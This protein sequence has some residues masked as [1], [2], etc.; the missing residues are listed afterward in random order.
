MDK[1]N[2]RIETAAV[3]I[4]DKMPDGTVYAGISLDTG[5]PTY[6][7]LASAPLTMTF[8]EA[9]KYVAKMNKE[10]TLSHDDWR[11]PT[12]GD[13]SMLFNHRAD[14]GN[15]GLSSSAKSCLYWSD[16]L[17]KQDDLAILKDFRT[18]EFVVD[19][20]AS[21]KHSVRCVR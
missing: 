6:T 9:G 14:I 11:L 16:K 18:G 21:Y 8:Y 7:T 1:N 3:K 20:A 5:K 15:F 4:G 10:K 12:E 13:L 2:E 17:I 19:C